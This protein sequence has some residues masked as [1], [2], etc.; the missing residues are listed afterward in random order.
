MTYKFNSRIVESALPVGF[1]FTSL[2]WTNKYRIQ[3]EI[4]YSTRKYRIQQGNIVFNKEI[5]YS[6][7]KYYIQQRN[8]VFAN[9]MTIFTFQVPPCTLISNMKQWFVW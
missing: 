7:R 5:S 3:Q 2:N 4:L 1:L 8:I 9:D 6:T